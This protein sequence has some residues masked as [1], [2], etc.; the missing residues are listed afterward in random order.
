[1]HSICILLDSV[2]NLLV[3]H[4][5]FVGNIA[6]HLKGL[7]PSLDFCC[8]GPA[9][10]G[11]KE[12]RWDERPHQLNLRSKRDVLVPPY[13]LQSRKSCCCLGCP[14]KN[15]GFWSYVRDDCP[16]VLEVFHFFQ[17]LTFYLS[18]S[19]EAIWVVCHHFCLVW[20]D[21]HFVPCGSSI[22]TV[23]QDAS[24]FFLFCIYD[25]VI[26]KAEV[27]NESSPDADT[28]FMVIQS[29]THDSL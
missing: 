28:A 20:T 17:P 5:V 3:R 26:C 25:N 22:K 29:L 23:Y 21:L 24:L 10:T 2:A 7:D 11:I 6:F 15:L 12:G 19:L 27:G 8:Q 14:G 18:L 9:L 1:M 16:K 13:D 4:M